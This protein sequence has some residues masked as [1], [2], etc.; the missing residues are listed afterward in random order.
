MKGARP[1]IY[2]DNAATTKPDSDV[3]DEL[4]LREISAFGNPSSPHG[5]ADFPKRF[6]AKAE[7]NVREA[8]GDDEGEGRVIFTSGGTEANNLALLGLSPVY[9]EHPWFPSHNSGPPDY[10]YN[11]IASATEHSS[12][13]E[14]LRHLH[15]IHPWIHV[16][17]ALPGRKGYLSVNDIMEHERAILDMYY[18][19]RS[20]TEIVSV[21]AVNNET[22]MM[23]DVEA[24][25]EFCRENRLIFHTD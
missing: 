11:I 19:A 23:N 10:A 17:E 7:E 1:T 3:I 16:I 25:G 5:L 24:I 2:L 18:I 20:F 22:G 9:L 6:L 15:K 4:A 12:V 8:V 13:L 14:P 21:M